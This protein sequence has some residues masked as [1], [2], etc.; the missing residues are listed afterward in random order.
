MDTKS[1]WEAP[2]AGPGIL[3]LLEHSDCEEGLDPYISG[4]LA[5]ELEAIL[6]MWPKDAN[7]FYI[8][9]AQELI[10]LAKKASD[11]NETLD[12]F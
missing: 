12:F 10:D 9:W 1:V 8:E 7:P 11:N 4:L 5:S 3:A 2:S 6:P